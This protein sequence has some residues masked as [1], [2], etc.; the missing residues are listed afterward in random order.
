MTDIDKSA[1]RK[2]EVGSKWL[3][4]II[5]TYLDDPALDQRNRFLLA[6]AAYNAR[7]NNLLKFHKKIVEHG[8]NRNLWLGNAESAT[9]EIVGAKT[10]QHVGI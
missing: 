4:Y 10:V 7:P 3:R 9:A 6:L 5:D 8:L 1:D 2:I